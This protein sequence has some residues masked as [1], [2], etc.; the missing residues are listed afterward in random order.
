MIT[1]MYS[2]C[3]M[4]DLRDLPPDRA[5]MLTNTIR[6][7]RARRVHVHPPPLLPSM[8]SSALNILDSAPMD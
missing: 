6:F 4:K 3:Y 7:T 8:S 1:Y 5:I 2:L